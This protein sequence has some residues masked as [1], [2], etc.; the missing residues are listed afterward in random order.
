MKTRRTQKKKQKKY[1][2]L[3]EDVKQEIIDYYSK[4]PIQNSLLHLKDKYQ[5]SIKNI[6]R[7]IRSGY[8]RKKG[9]GRKKLNEKAEEQLE[10][11]VKKQCIKQKKRVSRQ[12]IKI[13][14]I[15]F[16]KD[17]NF[18]ASKAW[19]D[20]FVR[21]KNIK[22]KQL[23]LLQEKGCL[24]YSQIKT[25]QQ[26]ISKSGKDIQSFRNEILQNYD[27]LSQPSFEDS[28]QCTNSI[29]K[30]YWNYEIF[31]QDSM[32]HFQELFL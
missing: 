16:F 2:I 18:K 13:Q 6:R 25:F 19:Q 30:Q 24:N 27:F 26:L 5:T 15:K 17:S 20:E 29:N 8:K 1:T 31:Q 22:I 10:L 12:Q 9:C 7:W 28:Q 23:L 11:W 3:T 21:S 32:M 14:A 4:H